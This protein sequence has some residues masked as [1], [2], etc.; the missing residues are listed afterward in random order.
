[1]KNVHPP[2]PSAGSRIG[3][4]RVALVGALAHCGQHVNRGH[5]V[6]LLVV[7]DDVHILDD[8][9][10]L[11]SGTTLHRGAASRVRSAL[12]PGFQL[13][14]LLYRVAD[15]AEA[16]QQ[17]VNDGGHDKSDGS[18]ASASSS[19]ER[20]SV[21]PPLLPLLGAAK[22]VGKPFLSHACKTS[23]MPR[24]ASPTPAA[25]ALCCL[26]ADSSKKVAAAQTAPSNELVAMI[27]KVEVRG[28]D[29]A[30][31]SN[32]GWLNDNVVNAYMGA[33]KLESASEH[34]G[35]NGPKRTLHVHAFNSFF[36]ELLSKKGRGYDYARVRKW[37]RRIDI[38]AL[39]KVLVPV[40]IDVHWTLAVLNMRKRRIEYYDSLGH[41]NQPCIDRLRR[42][43]EDEHKDKKGEPLADLAEWSKHVPANIPQQENGYDCGVFM[44]QYA[45]HARLHQDDDTDFAFAQSDVPTSRARIMLELLERDERKQ[46]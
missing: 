24:P 1:M 7:G 19:G 16:Q 36:Y 31:L 23:L 3:D 40:H 11:R 38:F 5:W 20:S 42:Y 33:I 30:R 13:S 21:L 45:L 9:Q 15:D 32:G 29:A 22:S 18:S 41:D 46:T 25:N 37:T 2:V 28:C 27:D 14:G 12:P 17:L 8:A 43:L 35:E 4:T 6:A 39:D 26:Q 10:Y 44:L 34:G